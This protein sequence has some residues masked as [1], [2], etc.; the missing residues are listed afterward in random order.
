M[1]P[2]LRKYFLS[3]EQKILANVYFLNQAVPNILKDGVSYDVYSE[4]FDE[5]DCF[6]V[7]DIV[8]RRKSK[9]PAARKYKIASKQ[10]NAGTPDFIINV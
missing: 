3:W 6:L 8:L 4:L 2:Y 10:L 1:N 7:L 5:V 9:A